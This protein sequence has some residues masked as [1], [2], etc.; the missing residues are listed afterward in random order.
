MARLTPARGAT[1][2]LVGALASAGVA[3][4]V[5]AAPGGNSGPGGATLAAARPA[6]P[7][8]GTGPGPA[9]VSLTVTGSPATLQLRPGDSASVQVT[10]QRTSVTGAVQ[11]SVSGLPSRTQASFS[12]NPLP[13]NGSTSTLTVQ[14]SNRTPQG[15][16]TLT[17]RATS[18]S[19][20]ATTT[21]SLLVER[22]GAPFTL[23]GP[24]GG[25]TGLAPGIDLPVNLLIDN[26]NG[27]ALKVTS[28]TV[29]LLSTSAPGCVAS[30]NYRVTQFSGSYPVTVPA[31]S[32]RTLRQLGFPQ[33][34]WPRLSMLN[35]PVNQD[36]CKGA[37]LR[38]SYSGTGD[39]GIA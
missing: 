14:T 20:T 7:G 31:G 35:L 12:P 6:R 19:L 30:E 21:V 15:R 39:G 34:A 24:R 27:T 23:S 38:L 10:L 1:V 17:L 8:P 4:V 16:S 13:G 22:P 26:P 25:A 11:L 36:A 9:A 29:S 3:T 33:S 28:L 32:R 18:G 2:L 5:R 37:T